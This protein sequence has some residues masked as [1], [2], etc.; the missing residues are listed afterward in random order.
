MIADVMTVN[1]TIAKIQIVKIANKLPK[2][3]NINCSVL[4]M[5]MTNILFL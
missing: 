4:F 3:Q 2:K 1:V 5:W